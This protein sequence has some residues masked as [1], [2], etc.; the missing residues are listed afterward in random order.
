MLPVLTKKEAELILK[1]KKEI[2][3]SLDLGISK[4]K[5]NIEDNI[6]LVR[7]ES[8]P[9][10]QFKNLKDD[11][12][13]VIENGKVLRIAFFSEKTNLYYKLMPTVD[14]PALTVS[15][16][17]MHRHTHISPKQSAESMVKMIK[18]VSGKVLDTCCGLG[19]TAILAAKHAKEVL[20]FER[21]EN[22][23]RMASYDPYS[24]NLFTSKNI[25][26][27]QLDIN[28]ALQEFEDETFQRVIHDPPTF[29]Y[30]PELYSRNF[31]RELYRVIK[32]NGILYHYCPSPGKTHG[33]DFSRGVLQRLKRAGFFSIQFNEESS[34]FRAVK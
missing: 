24:Q 28:E 20:T 14:W 32:K 13:Y 26:L 19:Y 21:D 2:S 34:G 22:V 15:S 10:E 3:I 25:H 5:V 11:V 4:E 8:I 30:S 7:N 29:K 16:T 1:E 18:P 17:P 27:E 9:L 31:Y 12:C 6:I 23:I 33:K